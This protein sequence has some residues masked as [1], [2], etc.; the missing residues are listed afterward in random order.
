[1]TH[2]QADVDHT[3][4]DTPQRV[5][6]QAARDP[7]RTGKHHTV[8]VPTMPEPRTAREEAEIDGRQCVTPT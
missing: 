3:S 7:S 1:M 4:V 5:Y 8:P 2:V 6:N